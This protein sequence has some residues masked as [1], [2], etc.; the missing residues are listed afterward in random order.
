MIIDC[1]ECE[2]YM[3]DHCQDCFVMA[4]LS[5]GKSGPL[6]IEADQEPAIATLQQAGL[7]PVLKFKRRVG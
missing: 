4:V 2:M 3:S 6:V 1:Q 7:A 5:R